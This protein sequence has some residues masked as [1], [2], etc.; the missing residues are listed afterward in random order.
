MTK[1][2]II[3]PTYNERKN[4]RE[5]IPAVF[6]SAPGA[7][8]MV[9]DDNS[10]DGTAEEVE[11]LR[12][13]Y[14]DLELL[15]REKKEGLGEA[16]IAAFKK[17]LSSDLYGKVV[18]MDGDFSHDPKYLPE[19]FRYAKYFP[20]VVGSRYVKGGATVGW[21]AHRRLLSR[22]GNLYARYVTNLPVRDCTGGFNC[23][24][25]EFLKRVDMEKLSRFK[26]Y[27][28]IMSLKYFLWKKRAVFKEI[29]IIFKNRTEGKSKLS[30]HIVAEGFVAPWLLL[31]SASRSRTND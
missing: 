2:I 20:V 23:I 5:L 3:I 26:G 15:R 24:D 28:F 4:I 10:P 6:A 8:V 27:A 25:A 14:P 12:K 9:V 18:M 21:E 19:M 11:N 16:Y 31:F 13:I 30:N 17:A 29:P 7:S 1:T 22:L